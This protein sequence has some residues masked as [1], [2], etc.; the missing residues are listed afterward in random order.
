VVSA[1]DNDTIRVWE[2]MSGIEF[3]RITVDD[4]V[5]SLSFSPD[6]KSISWEGG[7]YGSLQSRAWQPAELIA[8]ACA[9]MPRNLTPLEWDQ[10]IRDALPYQ[11]IC[12]D[13]PLEPATTGT[14]SPAP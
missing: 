1:A 11:A 6:G 14:P 13:L 4:V 3:A 5:D 7:S 2:A 10:Y 8:E 9:V 12:P